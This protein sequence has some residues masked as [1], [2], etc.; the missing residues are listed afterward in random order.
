MKFVFFSD[1]FFKRSRKRLERLLPAYFPID[2]CDNVKWHNALATTLGFYDAAQYKNNI[3]K[4]QRSGAI[5]SH[6]INHWNDELAAKLGNAYT[7]QFCLNGTSGT[8]T[9]HQKTKDYPDLLA[10]IFGFDNYDAY[11]SAQALSDQ[12]NYDLRL[13]EDLTEKACRA[14]WQFQLDLLIRH[15]TKRRVPGVTCENLRSLHIKWRPTANTPQIGLINSDKR[16]SFR[17]RRLHVKGFATLLRL[18]STSTQPNALD[19]E[20]AFPQISRHFS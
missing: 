18:T 12:P 10:E 15:L 11:C 14:R 3:C 17:D 5:A 7:Q 8:V 9:L 1:K 13:D 2:T 19:I 4:F 20:L 16:I 6:S